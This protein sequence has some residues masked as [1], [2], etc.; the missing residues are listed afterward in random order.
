VS[1]GTVFVDHR[2]NLTRFS[3]A[4]A[5]IF[6]LRDTDIG[7]PLEDLNHTLDYPE[8]MSDL[9][10]TLAQGVPFEKD[11]SG[12][13]ARHYLIKM[14]PYRVPSSST[15]EVAVSFVDMTSA[16]QVTQLQTILDGLSEQIAV[17]DLQGTITLVNR[18]WRR[19]AHDNGAS[20]L[21]HCGPGTNY[22]VA[23]EAGMAASADEVS[24]LE[25]P[26]G[27]SDAEYA[28]RAVHGLR[29]VLNGEVPQFRMEYPCHSPGCQRWFVM[30]ASPLY[31]HSPAHNVRGAVVS[32]IDITGWRRH[33]ESDAIALSRPFLERNSPP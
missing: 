9:R 27:L 14:Q 28:R 33:N 17:L 23:C 6:R 18:A 4:A 13:L 16:Y 22:L 26:M 30:S 32:H 5:H 1:S 24:G 31:H 29:S 12:P 7:R 2:L 19:F 20:E 21:R 8:F 10:Q 15:R 25:P 11:V 3:A